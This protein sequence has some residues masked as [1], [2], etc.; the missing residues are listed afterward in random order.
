MLGATLHGPQHVL[1]PTLALHVN[2]CHCKHAEHT[3]LHALGTCGTVAGT[4]LI[5]AIT[6]TRDPKPSSD[7]LQTVSVGTERC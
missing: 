2:T 4:A 6:I 1:F 5:Y 3:Q 7:T